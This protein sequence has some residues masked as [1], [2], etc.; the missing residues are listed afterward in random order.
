MEDGKKYRG[1][2]VEVKRRRPILKMRG[3]SLFS[4]VRIQKKAP[5]CSNGALLQ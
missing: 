5:F 1:S 3:G 2:R 4:P